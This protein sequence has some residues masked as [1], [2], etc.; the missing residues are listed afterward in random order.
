MNENCCANRPRARR[1]SRI[2]T[3][4]SCF[5]L[6]WRPYA[7]SGRFLAAFGRLSG[8]CPRMPTF[9]RHVALYLKLGFKVVGEWDVPEGGPHFWSML[10]NN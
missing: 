4:G 6:D 7:G 1:V 9:F 10:C 2:G 8:I 3:D 5:W